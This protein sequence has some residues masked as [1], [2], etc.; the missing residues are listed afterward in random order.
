MLLMKL[1]HAL[2]K[3]AH[4]EEMVVYP[5]LREAERGGRRRPARRRARLHQDLH[6]RTQRDGPGCAQL[7]REGPRVPRSSVAEHAQMEEEEVFPRFKQ[8]PDEEQNAKITSLVNRDGFWMASLADE[9]ELRRFLGRQV[10]RCLRRRCARCGRRAR[11]SSAK[12]RPATTI[13][14]P[15]D[16]SGTTKRTQAVAAARVG[17]LA[18]DRA[19]PI[20]ASEHADGHLQPRAL[21]EVGRAAGSA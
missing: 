13:A 12:S 17:Q 16:A 19:R 4:E 7:A 9:G 18:G 3:H 2:D 15:P 11:A 10:D 20:A 21:G 5:A 14:S 1:T 8:R 6:L